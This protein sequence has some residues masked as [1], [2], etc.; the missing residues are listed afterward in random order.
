MAAVIVSIMPVAIG[1]SSLQAVVFH[2]Y[3]FQESGYNMSYEVL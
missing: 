1:Q 3:F 2:E